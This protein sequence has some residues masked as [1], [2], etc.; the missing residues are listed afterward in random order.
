MYF[1][2]PSTTVSFLP[3]ARMPSCQ[4]ACQPVSLSSRRVFVPS[5]SHIDTCGSAVEGPDAGIPTSQRCLKRNKWPCMVTAC[6]FAFVSLPLLAPLRS[7]LPV[8]AVHS[9]PLVVQSCAMGTMRV[10]SLV[11]SVR[12]WKTAPPS[13]GLPQTRSSRFSGGGYVRMTDDG[14]NDSRQDD[15]PDVDQQEL[16][17]ATVELPPLMPPLE[18]ATGP[19]TRAS[20]ATGAFQKLPMVSPSYEIIDTALKRA[21][22]V[23]YNKKLKNDGARAKNRAAR[24]LDTLMKELTKPLGTYVDG[25]TH[26]DDLHPFERALLSLS[27]G[28]EQYTHCVEGVRSLRKSVVG[29]SKSYAGQCS[30]SPTKK[31]ALDLRDEGFAKVEST[32]KRYSYV[33]DELKEIAKSLR[34]LPVVDTELSTV[35]LVG[36][37]N[38]GKSS[39]VQLLSS[40]LPEIQNYPFTT[41]SIKM[42]HFYVNGRRCQ[43]TDTPGLLNRPEEDRNDMEMLTLASLQYLMTSVLFVMDL[44]GDCGTSLRDQ[45]AIRAELLERFPEKT[46]LDVF[47]K[48]DLLEAELREANALV[49][50]GASERILRDLEGDPKRSLTAAE[51]A[52]LV[53]TSGTTA[54]WVSSMTEE[55][56]D[57]LKHAMTDA[58]MPSV[59]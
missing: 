12:R 24:Q 31:E 14:A 27:I 18:R 7:R 34:K 33:L 4:S 36:A 39:L 13:R 1:Y 58:I 55:G 54:V 6:P 46:W 11:S 32:Y 40:G 26:P 16:G 29:V 41:R 2:L 5:S 49:A 38:V 42:G 30:K 44:T 35:A 8:D 53:S 22:R 57:A 19:R 23:G 3:N 25:F 43:V 45:W 59:I 48:A 47:S 9:F 15:L 20:G 10:M 50:E 37:P 52:C 21:E 28:E 51:L 17:S 56:I